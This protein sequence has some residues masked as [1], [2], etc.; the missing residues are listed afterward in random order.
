ML[1]IYEFTWNWGIIKLL[2]SCLS[3]SLVTH[4]MVN[5]NYVPTYPPCIVCNTVLNLTMSV[6]DPNV[7]CTWVRSQNITMHN[8]MIYHSLSYMV[9]THICIYTAILISTD[10][11]YI[12]S[13][14][15]RLVECVRVLFYFDNL[16]NTEI[17]IR[18]HQSPVEGRSIHCQCHIFIND[19]T[20]R[21]YQL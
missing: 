11:S 21:N 5:N 13:W 16:C 14:R 20:V 12:F 2:K 10:I 15:A 4:E 17:L 9:L 7:P 3:D 8:V 19:H 6:H 1:T 18:K